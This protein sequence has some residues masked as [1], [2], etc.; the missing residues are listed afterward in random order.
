MGTFFF[1]LWF[2]E[3][4]GCDFGFHLRFSIFSWGSHFRSENVRN[5]AR[6]CRKRIPCEKLYR[7]ASRSSQLRTIKPIS[8]PFLFSD[9]FWH[10]FA[11]IFQCGLFLSSTGF[12]KVYLIRLRVYTV[13]LSSKTPASTHPDSK[14]LIRKACVKKPQGACETLVKFLMSPPGGYPPGGYPP[15]GYPPGGH[16]PGETLG[17]A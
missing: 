15:G 5:R 13:G 14:F 7:I 3:G 9:R 17:I 8:W 10:I 12:C 6:E 1:H 2:L 16:P 4:L 11:S